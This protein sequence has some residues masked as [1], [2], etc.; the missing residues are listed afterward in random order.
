MNT[1][2]I[3]NKKNSQPTPCHKID[4]IN[5]QKFDYQPKV[6]F[7][8]AHTKDAIQLKFNV[9]EQYI[10]AQTKATNGEVYK[11]SCVEF[12][13]TFDNEHYYNFEFNCV[14]TRYLAYGANRNN[15]E[16]INP[17]IV[18]QITT[19]STLG[20]KTFQEKEGNF[21]WSMEINIPKSCF[22]YSD[23]KDF[24]GMEARANFYKCGDELTRPH[25]LTW[26]PIN[27]ENPD[28]HQIKYLAPVKFE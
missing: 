22:V 8:I 26:Q 4:T 3:Q 24:S 11:D 6:S 19:A 15:R 17:A 1:L 18:E 28:F 10:L 21:S 20:D 14:G 23:I 16:K 27:T 7:C 5:W 25:F 2:L 13:I 12:F 9:E